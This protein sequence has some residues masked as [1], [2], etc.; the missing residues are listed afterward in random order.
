VDGRLAAQRAEKVRAPSHV[1]PLPPPPRGARAGVIPGDQ[2]RLGGREEAWLCG[3]AA[4]ARLA[5]SS[6]DCCFFA[7]SKPGS[8]R[9]YCHGF[10][11]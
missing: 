7:L 9:Y 6:W 5:C 11:K 8:M 4:Q 10:S 2:S 3:W 1:H